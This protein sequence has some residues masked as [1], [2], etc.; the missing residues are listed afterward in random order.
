MNHVLNDVTNDADD[1][2]A[3]TQSDRPLDADL[4]EAVAA[5]VQGTE[6]R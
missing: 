1:L 3:Y 6:G 2:A 5:F 4:I